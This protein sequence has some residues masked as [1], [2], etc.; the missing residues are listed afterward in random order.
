[1]HFELS[2]PTARPP[3]IAPLG[4]AFPIAPTFFRCR[5]VSLYTP[6]DFPY[7]SRGDGVAGG[8]AAQAALWRVIS[9]SGVSLRSHRLSR[10]RGQLRLRELA[11]ASATYDREMGNPL[12]SLF[13][14]LCLVSPSAPK[15]ATAGL[16][17]IWGVLGFSSKQAWSATLHKLGMTGGRRGE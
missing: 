8:I 5:R 9:Y 2:D 6:R 7:R 1:M 14:V 17:A 11:P 10:L 4:I 16:L 15:M 3:P 12:I 13:L